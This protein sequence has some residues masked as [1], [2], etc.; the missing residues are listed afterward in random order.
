[1]DT[2][3]FP[4]WSKT[5][6]SSYYDYYILPSRKPIAPIVSSRGCRLKCSFCS[7]PNVW[8]GSYRLR[9]IPNIMDEIDMLLTEYKVR[10]I[11][12][13]D[14]MLAMEVGRIEELSRS[15]IEKNYSDFKWMC[16]L[17]PLSLGN[18]SARLMWLMKK[19]G[20]VLISFGLQSTN[21]EI[22]KNIRR[23]PLEPQALEN[24]IKNASKVGILTAVDFIF[25]L[26]GE[27][28]ETIRESQRYA[29][30]TRPDFVNFHTF[31]F[32]PGAELDEKYKGCSY[33]SLNGF[34]KPELENI[35]RRANLRF[36]FNPRVLFNTLKLIYKYAPEHLYSFL[37]DFILNIFNF[38]K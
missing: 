29:L 21:P 8:R 19:A 22:L 26:P 30:R 31:S 14:D 32:V 35:C 33:S 27:T 36:Y 25:G 11:I 6:L 23:S 5:D 17:H 1:M 20:C 18:D 9:S 10:F 34:T 2:I 12:F 3:S 15:I 7:T 16:I 24:N 38:F 28:S 4:D 37:K 13:Q